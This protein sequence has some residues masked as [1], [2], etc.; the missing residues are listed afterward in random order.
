MQFVELYD[1]FEICNRIILESGL[2]G[3][4]FILKQQ[5][6]TGDRSWP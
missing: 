4:T 6:T 5:D 1:K 2:L 3:G